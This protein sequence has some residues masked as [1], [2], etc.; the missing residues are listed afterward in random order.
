MAVGRIR[1]DSAT[2]A[3]QS[4]IL[5]FGRDLREDNRKRTRSLSDT[6]SSRRRMGA[7]GAVEDRSKPIANGRYRQAAT[8]RSANLSLFLSNARIVVSAS[9][10]LG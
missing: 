3:L 7:S 2:Y 9:T 4:A 5:A 10:S 8:I 6:C 1:Q